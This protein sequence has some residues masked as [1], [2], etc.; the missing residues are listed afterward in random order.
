MGFKLS[1]YLS[2]AMTGPH[3][4]QQAR[5]APHLPHYM[6]P[7]LQCEVCRIGFRVIMMLVRISGL[8]SEHVWLRKKMGRGAGGGGGGE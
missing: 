3:W 4:L 1:K 5:K 6:L 2:V 7:E 8:D